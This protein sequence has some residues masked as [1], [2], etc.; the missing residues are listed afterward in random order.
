MAW[1]G[2]GARVRQDQ[3]GGEIGPLGGKSDLPAVN[4]VMAGFAGREDDLLAGI[5]IPA[6][7]GEQPVADSIS[8]S[9]Q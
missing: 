8:S 9:Y 1:T 6:Q 7:N 3:F 5:S 4:I 2:V